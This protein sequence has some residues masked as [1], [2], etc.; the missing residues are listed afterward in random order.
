MKKWQ[1]VALS[2]VTVLSVVTLAAGCSAGKKNKATSDN[3][4]A[5]QISFS[6]WGNDDR[7]KA[8]QDMING[9]EKEHKDIKVKGGPSG[10]GDLDQVFTTRYAGNTFADVTTLLYNWVPQFGQNGGFY[11]LSTIK[12]LDLSTY[13]KDF[14]KFG[15]VD[16]KQVAV[17]YGQNTLV[18]YVNKTA[19]ERNDIDVASLKTW[20][21]YAA[22]AKKL[23]EGSFMIASPTWRFPVTNWLQQK[24]GKAEFDEKGDLN[25]SEQDYLDGMTWY[26]E[27]ADAHVFVSR[28]DYL[29][30]VGTEP[31]SLATNKKW[32]DG[33][34][35]GGIGWNA[36]ITSDYESL[37]EV[38]DELVIVDYPIAKGGKKVNLLSKPSL[39][40]G[41]KKNEKNPEQVG[42]FL[43]DFLNG[44]EANKTLGLSRGIPASSKAVDVLTKD[45]K[46]TG[47]MKDGFDYAQDAVKINETPFYEDGT[48]TTIYTTEIEAVEL[49]KTDLK[50]AAKNVYT[51]T[52]DQAAK[53]AKDYKLK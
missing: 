33:E 25:W 7:H 40:F 32:L 6:W 5:V 42:T 37:K 17:P 36:G 53:L 15:Q 35:G 28:K 26:K 3:K 20:D 48:L 16:G 14:L 49:G 31:V 19:Y 52:K 39:L 51:K 23:P 43:N 9:F 24:T 27:M 30:N 45:G 29:E 18:M 34:Y 12:S 44:E 47:F 41:V 50:T 4:G 2:A 8:T 38:G 13:D 46:L 11:D 10:F 21:D 1:K 22:A